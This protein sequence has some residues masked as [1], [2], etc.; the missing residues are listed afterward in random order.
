MHME[1]KLLEIIARLT[2][3]SERCKV[4]AMRAKKDNQ[5]ALAH[6][7]LAMGESHAMQAKRFL[8]QVRGTIGTTEENAK[9]AFTNEIPSAIRE[10]ELLL[11]EADLEGNKALAT[12]YRHSGEVESRTLELYDLYN[13]QKQD[14]EYYVCD[15]CGYIAD[16]EAPDN[17]PVCTAPKNRFKKI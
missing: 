8:M 17:C 10:Y 7:F 16:G 2:K 6:L 1:N 13:E 4:Y 3:S 15:F 9:A 11:K 14:R 5:P 12:G